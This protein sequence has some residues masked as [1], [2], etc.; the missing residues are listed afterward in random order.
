MQKVNLG[1]VETT[2]ESAPLGSRMEANHLRFTIGDLVFDVRRAEC[3]AVLRD[4][5]NGPELRWELDVHGE[6]PGPDGSIWRPRATTS[7]GGLRTPVA[8][9]RMLT[10]VTWRG[11]SD[12]D[13]EGR[14]G[15]FY[16]HEHGHF[17]NSDISIARCGV[18][19]NIDWSG[20]CDVNWSPQYRGRNFAIRAAAVAV[21]DIEAGS[22]DEARRLVARELDLSQFDMSAV[23]KSRHH[24]RLRVR[25]VNT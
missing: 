20:E 5:A 21:L 23:T 2:T 11:Q 8:C 24:G 12:S 10:T 9:G 6:G 25:F 19:W 13:E 16:V 3:V 17:R 22:I 1:R 15:S 14:I 18:S 7:N 4:G